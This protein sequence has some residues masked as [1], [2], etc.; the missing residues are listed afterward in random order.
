MRYA[1]CIMNYALKKHKKME[2]QEVTKRQ[3][4]KPEIEVIE[5]DAEPQLLAASGGP[6]QYNGS[7]D[8]FFDAG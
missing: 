2:N 8:H 5:L 6:K 3:Y 4:E 1:L 7:P